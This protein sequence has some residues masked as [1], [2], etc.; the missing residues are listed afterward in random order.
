VE[1][2]MDKGWVDYTVAAVQIMS[3]IALVIYV[4][5]TWEMASATRE[6][7]EISA[8]VLEHNRNVQD[9]EVAPYMVVYLDI[10]Y[11]DPWIY[12]VVRNV[13]KTIAENVSITFDPPL[14]RMQHEPLATLPIDDAQMGSFPP[15]YEVRIFFDSTIEYFA[16]ENLPSSFK[17]T[18]SYTGGLSPA[19]RSTTQII[20][21]SVYKG[22][23]YLHEPRLKD[24]LK[25]LKELARQN[26]TV[27]E[28]LSKLVSSLNRGIW[29]QGVGITQNTQHLDAESWQMGVISQLRE[30]QTLWSDIY[31]SLGEHTYSAQIDNLRGRTA[32][33]RTQMVATIANPPSTVTAPILAALLQVTAKLFA[34]DS[35]YVMRALISGHPGIA[36]FQEELIPLVVGA[37]D[38]LSS[39]KPASSGLNRPVRSDKRRSRRHID[40]LSKSVEKEPGIGTSEPNEAQT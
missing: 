11:G 37:I 30:L 2:E 38:L 20:D 3:L 25:E 24:V 15:G 13:G 14:T 8:K 17:V 32:I 12:L 29:V 35:P 9:Q 40:N 6:A 27:A 21:L 10:P 36:K 28:Q 18:A 33:I 4:I 1:G 23:S 19:P 5:K 7:A 31:A 26:K 39:N 16:Q 22:T 34:L